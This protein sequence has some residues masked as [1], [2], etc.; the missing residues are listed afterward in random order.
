MTLGPAVVLGLTPIGPTR[1]PWSGGRHGRAR[2]DKAQYV[3]LRD[4][5]ARASAFEARDVYAVLAGDVAYERARTR[6]P[7]LFDGLLATIAARSGCRSGTCGRC[8]RGRLRR[9]ASSCL[10]LSGGG[11][12]RRWR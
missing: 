9:G 11:G 1:P 4:A 2:F 7:K 12:L 10:L 6:A 5:P 3:V 8:L